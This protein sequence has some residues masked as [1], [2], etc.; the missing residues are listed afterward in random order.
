MAN[1]TDILVNPHARRL[2]QA[3]GLIA[4]IRALANGRARVHV[5][6]SLDE[7]ADAAPDEIKDDWEILADGFDKILEAFEKAGIDAEDLEAIQKGETPEGVDMTKL[8]EA[9]A[10]LEELNS[11]EYQEA[12]DNISKHAKD[13]CD[14]DLDA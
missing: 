6:R 10:E 2:R 14:I 11:E 7:L 13:E 8:Q 5:T 1:V 3:P 9:F 12:S 4:R